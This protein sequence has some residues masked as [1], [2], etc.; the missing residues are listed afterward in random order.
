[1]DRLVSD[2]HAAAQHNIGAIQTIFIGGGTP[3]L[4]AVGLWERL[5]RALHATFE[6]A[7]D[8]E[9]TVEANPETVT[10]ELLNVLT[11][12]G[13][14]RL[15]IGA[16]SFDPAALKML[17]RWHDPANVQRSVSLARAAGIEN[18]NLDLIFAI[19]GETLIDWAH[20]LDTALALHPDHLS[21]YGLMYEPNTPMTMRLKQGKLHRADDELEAQMYQHTIDRLAQA[22]FEQYEISNWSLPGRRCQ[23]N[24][25]YWH[26]A[27]WWACG[28]GA[29]AHVNGWRWKNIP[30]LDAY[31]DGDALPEIQDVEHLD[32]DGRI[33]EALM[34]RLRLLDGI[35]SSELDSLLNATASGPLRRASID[36]NLENGL[37]E[38]CDDTI[39][40]TNRGLLLADSIVLELL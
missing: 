40:M 22:G 33:G 29:A 3:T 13:V 7:C 16:Q 2:F 19:P 11:A 24:L 23:H 5:L 38:V 25:L 27:D 39:R 35:A 20:D 18:I 9:F 32:E 10:A 31:I 34:L 30:R 1:M 8:V 4:L 28:P 15:S 12:G 17:E 37:L 36:R 14:N 26:N 6:I 21:C